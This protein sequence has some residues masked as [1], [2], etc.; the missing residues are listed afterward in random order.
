MINNNPGRKVGN[1]DT[2]RI[3]TPSFSF[4]SNTDVAVYVSDLAKAEEFYEDV[5]GFRL[6]SKSKDHLEYDSGALRLYIHRGDPSPLFIPSLDVNDLAGASKY[7]ENAGCTLIPLP[8]GGMVVRD[9]FGFLF[10]LI[11]RPRE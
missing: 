3:K 9:P 6:V 1:R 7:L 10:D 11:E 4:R 5:L 2:K 8:G